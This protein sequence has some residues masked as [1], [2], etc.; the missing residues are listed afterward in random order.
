M[1]GKNQSYTEHAAQRAVDKIQNAVLAVYSGIL[2][3]FLKFKG[4]CLLAILVGFFA[5]L[6]LFTQ[7]EQELLP[8]VDQGQFFIE[9]NLPTGTRLEITN[10]NTKKIETEVLKVP[11]LKNISTN[12]GSDKSKAGEG[13]STLGSH[14]SR[15]VVNL[16]SS[17]KRHTK[18]IIQSLKEN[19]DKLGIKNAEINFVSNDSAFGAAVGGGGAAIT[20][21]I[22]GQDL[23]KLA[24]L[25]QQIQN[26]LKS[27]QGVYNI[28]DSTSEPF[29]ETRINIDKEKAAYFGLSVNDIALTCQMAI[30]V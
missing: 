8:R 28:K 19:V 20:I 12:V 22:L 25:N 16:K 1:R 9:L 4:V 3:G 18:D 13:T 14:Q 10:N 15:M 6:W 26:K 7:L 24:E 30:K 17:R 23:E 2:K 11:E 27:I 21:E 5:S 29:P